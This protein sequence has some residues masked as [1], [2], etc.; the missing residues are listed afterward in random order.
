MITKRSGGSFNNDA[1]CCY[2]RIAPPHAMLRC[3]RIGLPKLSAKMLTNIL[4][5]AMYNLKT[6]HRL[7]ARVYMSN[8]VCRILGIGQGSGASPCI[9][10]LVLD[11]IIWSVAT[12][13]TCFKLISLSGINISKVGDAFVDYIS[14]FLLTPS[15]EDS[16]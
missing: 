2:D 3:R 12:K 16:K 11:T 5:T 6:G 9:W 4:K 1:E 7:S 15:Q 13:H 14:I 10:E 8:K